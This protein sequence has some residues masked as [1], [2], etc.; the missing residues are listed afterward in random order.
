MHRF[1]SRIA[2]CLLFSGCGG[3]AQLYEVPADEAVV[4]ATPN[5]TTETTPP[6]I[7]APDLT[8]SAASGASIVDGELPSTITAPPVVI[9]NAPAKTTE[10]QLGSTTAPYGFVEYLPQGYDENGPE[11]PLMIMLHGLGEIGNGT[12]DLSKVRW[13]GPNAE[14]DYRGASFPMVILSPQSPGWWDGGTLKTFLDY[15]LQT[16]RVDPKRVYLTGLSMGGGGTFDFAAGFANRLAAIVPICAASGGGN[17]SSG[18]TL[19]NAGVAVWATHAVDDPT[20]PIANTKGWMT[21]IGHALGQPATDDAFA[22]FPTGTNEWKTGRY[23]DATKS[24]IWVTGQD[25][26]DSNGTPYPQKHLVTVYP[27][28]GHFIWNNLYGDPK[29]YEWLL[30]QSRP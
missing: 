5:T 22:Q 6:I 14:I 28:G 25:Y 12:T 15:A 27:S 8:A 4:V 19:V 1:V 7:T 16:Y 13:N 23:D 26:R 24:W 29:L 11:F 9:S 3:E 21:G 18:A 10:R 20:V 30:R 2:L 17:D